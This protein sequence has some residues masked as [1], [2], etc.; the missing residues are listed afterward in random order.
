M[1]VLVCTPLVPPFSFLLLREPLPVAVPLLLLP[2]VLELRDAL[3]LVDHACEDVPPN[4]V[5]P[6]YTPSA[7]YHVTAYCPFPSVSS[8][9]AMRLA[10]DSIC[11]PMHTSDETRNW[12]RTDRS[13]KRLP[14]G[15]EHH[16]TLVEVHASLSVA[17]TWCKQNVTCASYVPRVFRRCQVREKVY[18]T[19]HRNRPHHRTLCMRKC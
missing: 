10:Q 19:L 11:L 13:Q 12:S 6:H 16:Q 14:R 9:F 4:V 5:S 3:Q 18:Y 8:P 1:H 7:Q 15:I 2:H 17:T